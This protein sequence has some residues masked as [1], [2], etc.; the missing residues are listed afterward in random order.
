MNRQIDYQRAY[1][2]M[3]NNTV[4]L[5]QTK[6]FRIVHLQIPSSSE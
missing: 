4:Q 2:N 1:S 5:R 6:Y 3:E